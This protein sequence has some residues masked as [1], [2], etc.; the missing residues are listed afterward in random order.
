MSALSIARVSHEAA[1]GVTTIRSLDACSRVRLVAFEGQLDVP[2]NDV[3]RAQCRDCGERLKQM[4]QRDSQKI[5]VDAIYASP[6]QRT[7]ESA[8]IIRK[9]SG[10]ECKVVLDDRIR[11]WN[12]G[13]LQ[14]H[15]LDEL[16]IKFPK[17]WKAWNSCR[18]PNFVFPEGESFQHR[19]DRVK[20]FFLEMAERHVGQRVVVVTHGGV[21]DDLFRLVRKIPMKIKTNAPKVNA[22]IHIVRAHV[23]PGEQNNVKDSRKI[24]LGLSDNCMQKNDN[25][26]IEWE[27]MAWGKLKKNDK[28]VTGDPGNSPIDISVRNIE[29]A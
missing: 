6:L 9:V 13:V 17:E 29:Y 18:D 16:S 20:D 7:K 8:E 4:F 21:L 2:L 15:L 24:P 19:Y 5:A 1:L 26:E 22:E 10:I 12:A 25:L 28:L 14:G 27:I 23:S 11:E 3:G